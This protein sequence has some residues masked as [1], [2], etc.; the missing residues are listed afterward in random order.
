MADTGTYVYCLV[1]AARRPAR[2]SGRAGRAIPSGLPGA[3][4]VRLLPVDTA[5]PSRKAAGRGPA[6]LGRWLVV[7]DAPLDRYGETVLNRNMSNLDWV[8]RAAV[9]HEAVVEGFSAAPAVLPM[10]LF[11]IFASDDRAVE[12]I[13]VERDQINR[14]IARVAQRDEWGVRVVLDRAKAASGGAATKRGSSP[15]GVAYL[16]RKKAARDATA[17]LER[18]AKK[19]VRDVY[20]ALGSQSDE[21]KRRAASELPASGGLMLLDAVFLVPRG[22][23]AQFRSAVGLHARTLGPRGYRISL[24]GPWPPYSFLQG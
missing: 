12:H 21:A 10:K 6:A 13:T 19:V 3:G 15:T 16:A 24:S 9:A 5:R 18:K 7:A 14:L 22:R 4:R 1:A 8:S 2:R 23:A 11:T 20:G 17:E